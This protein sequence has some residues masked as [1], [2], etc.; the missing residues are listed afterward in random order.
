MASKLGLSD[1]QQTE[2]LRL[3]KERYKKAVEYDNHN[4]RAAIEVLEFQEGIN[5]WDAAEVRRRTLHNRPFLKINV[6]PKYAKQVTGE[7]RKNKIRIRIHP[8]DTKADTH[9]AKIR[10]GIIHDIEYKS[11]AESIYDYVGDLLVKCGYGAWRV[12]TKHTEANPFIQEIYMDRIENPLS[13][14]MDPTSKSQFYADAEYGFISDEIDRDTFKSLYGK[15]RYASSGFDSIPSTGTVNSYWWNDQ[16]VVVAEYFFREKTKKTMALLSDGQIMELKKAEEYIREVTVNTA[17]SGPQVSKYIPEIMKEQE[18]EESHFKWVKMT[19][20]EIL[21]YKEWAGKYIPIILV[22]GEETNIRGKKYRKGLLNNAMDSQR[23]LNYWHTSA[24]ETVALQP[25]APWQATAKMI[26]GRE[27]DYLRAHEDNLPVLLYV[28]DPDRP[29]DKPSRTPPAVGNPALFTEIGRAEQNIKDSI[30]MYNAD[31][32][33]QGRELSGRAILARQAPGDT[34]TYIYPD[35]MAKAVAH[36][37]KILNDLIPKIMDTERDARLRNIDDSESFVPINTTVGKAVEAIHSDPAKFSGIDEDKLKA[38]ASKQNGALTVFN[39]IRQGNYDVVVTTGPAYATQRMESAERMMQFAQAS[40]VGMSPLDKY[41]VIKNV[42]WFG[43]DEYAEAIRK[44][45]PPGVLPLRPGEKPPPP[46]PPDPRLQVELAKL[47]VQEGERYLQVEKMKTERARQR[48][49]LVKMLTEM[50]ESDINA[51]KAIMDNLERLNRE[52]ER[53]GPT[54]PP[55]ASV[56]PR[57]NQP[58]E[59]LTAR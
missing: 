48:V 4:R 19:G 41:Y 59:A 54:G 18:I 5:Q 57:E 32:G 14:F 9:I 40:A 45:I 15:D 2:I 23:M 34:S 3:A 22:T 17:Q 39:D 27:K 26:E 36:C 20:A 25:K 8:A 21:D 55:V 28:N 7:M 37:G 29:G 42:D 6:L 47:K 35:S 44:T 50:K 31:V 16:M 1:E 10:E 53:Q 43:S 33:D 52:Y 12:L 49:Q 11:D 58:L 56:I 13:V 24:A 46:P 38:A 51:R 30:G